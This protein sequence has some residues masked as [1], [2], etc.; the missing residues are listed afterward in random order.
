MCVTTI[1]FASSTTHARCNKRTAELFF[2][3]LASV[4]P[5][6]V[7]EFALFLEAPSIFGVPFQ[8]SEMEFS[9]VAGPLFL[10][11]P[12]CFRRRLVGVF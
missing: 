11:A 7:L 2:L 3:R 6:Q 5:R 4:C 8:S 9:D 12:G 1:H 10:D